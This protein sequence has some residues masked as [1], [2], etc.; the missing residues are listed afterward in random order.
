MLTK[1]D[2]RREARPVCRN[3]NLVDYA[4][5]DET[6][7]LTL[8]GAVVECRGEA[9]T[10]AAAHDRVAARMPTSAV[11]P[12]VAAAWNAM[13]TLRA[14]QGRLGPWLDVVEGV[15]KRNVAR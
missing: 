7:T 3:D 9:T 12:Y 1:C 15:V 2:I 13:E 5:G 4:P 11:R 6:R 14:R 10:V 8:T